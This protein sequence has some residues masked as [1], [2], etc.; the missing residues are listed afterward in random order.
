MGLLPRA[1]VDINSPPRPLLHTRRAHMEIQR[2]GKAPLGPFG[3]YRPVF[4]LIGLIS[5]L[6]IACEHHLQVE[7]QDRRHTPLGPLRPLFLK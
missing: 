3:A 7:D 5:R 1:G 6:D 2:H 4:Q